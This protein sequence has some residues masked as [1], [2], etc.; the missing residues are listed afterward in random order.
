MFRD[1]LIPEGRT[2][3]LYADSGQYPTKPAYKTTK[4]TCYLFNTLI[5]QNILWQ[6]SLMLKATNH[7]KLEYISS[8]GSRTTDK[9]IQPRRWASWWCVLPACCSLTQSRWYH[10]AETAAESPA[11]TTTRPLT[12]PVAQWPLLS[13]AGQ[14]Q[15]W[16]AW[17]HQGWARHCPHQLVHWGSLPLAR[18]RRP[19]HYQWRRLRPMSRRCL[20][21]WPHELVL[22][23]HI[24]ACTSFAQSSQ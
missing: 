2:S 18:C 16:L 7:K 19:W 17:H 9:C 12:S 8:T 6:K 5:Q 15:Q 20:K 10:P 22:T 4:D 1:R 21:L 11:W 24:T 23:A 13:L 3:H 14:L